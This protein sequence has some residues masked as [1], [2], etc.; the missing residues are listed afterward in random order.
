M[1]F[2]VVI[3]FVAFFKEREV[4]KND[5]D[6]KGVCYLSREAERETLF[7]LDFQKLR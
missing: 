4:G 6:A 3:N 1:S 7:E 2:I 5:Y